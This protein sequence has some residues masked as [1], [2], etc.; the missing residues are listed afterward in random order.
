[1]E[2]FHSGFIALAGR[3]NAGKSTLLNAL[4]GEKV[5][6]VSPRPQTTRSKL[7]GI[8]NGENCQLVF[9]DTPGIHHPRSKLGSYMMQSVQ[10][11]L[12]GADAVVYV[13]DASTSLSTDEPLIDDLLSHHKTVFLV[14]NKIDLVKPEELLPSIQRM[15]SRSFHAILPVSARTREGLDS[16]LAE[17]TAVLPIGPRYYPEDM[18]T[19]QPERILCA[20]IIRE[21]A[22]CLLRDEVPHGIGV[23]IQ[24]IA[25][26]RSDLT[27]IHADLYC[28][29]SAHK[30]III[31]HHGIM[32]QRIGSEARKEIELL[33]GTHVNLQLWVRVRPDWRNSNADLK[34]L[35]YYHD[36]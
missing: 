26:I 19:D 8:L 7:C 3:P 31:G 16:L 5:A 33:L 6:I 14:L 11:G 24:K 4:V 30:A 20:E 9:V 35:G 17:L 22:L 23:E 32:L 12:S 28:E 15:S 10:E 34:T 2:A 25:V 27:E 18:I 21:K 36:A 29:K 1:M 13:A